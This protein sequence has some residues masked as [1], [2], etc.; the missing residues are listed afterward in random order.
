[1]SCS[2]ASLFLSSEISLSSLTIDFTI[3]QISTEKSNYIL[4]LYFQI[5]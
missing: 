4:K 1:M 5:K 2:L 3:T